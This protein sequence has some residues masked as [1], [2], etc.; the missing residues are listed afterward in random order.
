MNRVSSAIVQPTIIATGA[1]IFLYAYNQ[2]LRPI[3]YFAHLPFW[4]TVVRPLGLYWHSVSD[5]LKIE[6]SK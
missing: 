4:I 3:D 5:D 2:N 1:S 6:I